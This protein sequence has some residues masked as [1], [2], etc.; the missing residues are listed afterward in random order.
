MVP[1]QMTRLDKKMVPVQM[2][3]L[4]KGDGWTGGERC[5]FVDLK[6]STFFKSPT[7]IA[8]DRKIVQRSRGKI[9]PEQPRG[10]KKRPDDKWVL[11]GVRSEL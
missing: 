5:K 11:F 1:V 10:G 6:K 8:W 4:D 2:T 7:Q 3:C 9:N